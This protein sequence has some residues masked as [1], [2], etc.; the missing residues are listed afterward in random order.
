VDGEFYLVDA[1]VDGDFDVILD[2]MGNPVADLTGANDQL[3]TITD[4]ETQMNENYVAPTETDTLIAQ[5]NMIGE[6]I[7]QDIIIVDD[8]A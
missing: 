5:H 1:D 8:Q 6:N 7:Q 2:R 3:V 4:V